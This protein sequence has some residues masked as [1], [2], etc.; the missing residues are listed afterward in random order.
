[1]PDTY[2]LVLDHGRTF[3]NGGVQ[4]VD[5]NLDESPMSW[6]QLLGV[7]K[8]T[9]ALD[10]AAVT[11]NW[12]GS[13]S[14][15]SPSHS[16][17]WELHHAGDTT[18]FNDPDNNRIQIQQQTDGTYKLQLQTEYG[19][20]VG[21]PL[22]PVSG[23][24]S[25]TQKITKM[26]LFQQ[27]QELNVPGRVKIFDGITKTANGGY[28]EFTNG[29]PFPW[30]GMHDKRVTDHSTLASF[31]SGLA[32]YAK[33]PTDARVT[34]Y[35]ERV[36]EYGIPNYGD[37]RMCLRLNSVST[38]LKTIKGDKLV[39]AQVNAR[40]LSGTKGHQNDDGLVADINN[41]QG[42]DNRSVAETVLFGQTLTDLENM[43]DQS[44]ADTAL[45]NLLDGIRNHG[46]FSSQ[47]AADKRDVLS[48]ITKYATDLL[49]QL[50]LRKFVVPLETFLPFVSN[51]TSDAGVA[52]AAASAVEIVPSSR[53]PVDLSSDR[54]VYVPF[55][56]WDE[57]TMGFLGATV[58]MAFHGSNYELFTRPTHWVTPMALIVQ[59]AKDA[60]GD[61]VGTLDSI[62]ALGAAGTARKLTVGARHAFF[63]SARGSG[64]IGGVIG[65]PTGG[66]AAEQAT[67][68]VADLGAQTQTAVADLATTIT[69]ADTAAIESSAKTESEAALDLINP[70][71]NTAFA[72]K[73]DNEKREVL[74]T[75][76]KQAVVAAVAAAASAGTSVAK[77]EIDTAKFTAC[78]PTLATDAQNALESAT[79]VEVV[80]PDATVT[81]DADAAVYC[82]LAG[83]ETVTLSFEGTE[84]QWTKD[85]DGSVIPYITS[86]DGVLT[87][88][89]SLNP[90]ET[91]SLV[92]NG[93]IMHFFAGS[94]GGAPGGSAGGGGSG[95]PFL[96]AFCS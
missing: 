50:D 81:V 80:P 76:M 68:A 54:A 88:F 53:V 63:I 37:W 60:N 90:G 22:D 14:Y 65:V 87:P 20:N 16:L 74:R 75:V 93:Q 5:E 71:T 89:R 92:A 94:V 95:D 33:P 78:V 48:K 58:P 38:T 23:T 86:G 72:S 51:D 15:S 12:Y 46:N 52:L 47:S 28:A 82:P 35:N 57:T 49:A 3:A 9:A 77:I 30:S 7:G 84:V 67:A 17:L 11:S 32:D 91:A 24:S 6:H 21:D 2:T 42:Y 69:G 31:I 45:T 19:T 34:Q 10:D 44:T 79:K 73:P 18:L 61:S 85:A 55:K 4:A 40:M 70:T 41:I 43:T 8:I 26:G 25:P 13:S 27:D 1:M 66:S 96:Y 83:G 64:A 59:G 29:I 62:S 36:E 39:G 56:A